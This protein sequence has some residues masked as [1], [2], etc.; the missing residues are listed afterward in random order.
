MAK[1]SPKHFHSKA[2]EFHASILKCRDLEEDE[3]PVFAATC[4]NLSLFYRLSDE[5]EKTGYSFVS[6]NG[7]PHK[8]PLLSER[9]NA[10]A[11]FLAGLRILNFSEAEIPK[12]PGRP[13]ELSLVGG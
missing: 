10:W 4:E 11:A 6:A 9:K 1:H 8:N 13:S 2:K 7:V 12:R 3:Y 5:I